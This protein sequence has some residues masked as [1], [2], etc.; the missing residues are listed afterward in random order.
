MGSGGGIWS[1]SSR[2]TDEGRVERWE[3]KNS[4]QVNRDYYG[5]HARGGSVYIKALNPIWSTLYCF[6]TPKSLCVMTERC[7]NMTK[8]EEVKT[9]VEHWIG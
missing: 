5:R 8:R 9:S 2:F 6:T 3:Y 7:P 4:E 1:L